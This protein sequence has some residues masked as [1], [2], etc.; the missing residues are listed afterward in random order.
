MSLDVVTLG[1]SRRDDDT[2]AALVQAMLE[3]GEGES[4]SFGEVAMYGSLGVTALPYPADKSGHAEGVVVRGIAN[5]N[6]AVVAARDTRT[7]D[8]TAALK[9]GETCVHSTGPGFESR[10]FYKDK[11]IAHVIGDDFAVVHDGKGEKYSITAFGLHFEM[12]KRQGFLLESGGA[13]ISIN[14]GVVHIRGKVIL[15]GMGATPAS[16]VLYGVSGPA[17]VPALGVFIGL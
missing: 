4:E 14:N 10:T 12:S 17:A 1:A 15:G 6:G 7:A 2:N 11:L 3:I 13:G 16:A 8:V 5:G 9:P